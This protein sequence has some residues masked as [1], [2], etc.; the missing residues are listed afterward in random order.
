LYRDSS[1]ENRSRRWYPIR[2]IA[3]DHVTTVHDT[4]F[5]GV[6]EEVMMEKSVDWAT[7]FK[8]NTSNGFY[9]FAQNNP[10]T[11]FI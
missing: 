6:G 3:G 11:G 5:L 8:G 9:F 2:R 1:N 10:T 7:R 4:H